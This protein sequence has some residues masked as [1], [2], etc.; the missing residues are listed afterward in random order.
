MI[1]DGETAAEALQSG[2]IDIFATSSGQVINDF[3]QMGDDSAI[4]LQ[5]ELTETNFIIIDQSKQNALADRRVRCALSMAID[6][7]ELIDATDGGITEPANGLFSPGQQG[8]LEDN[9]LV[10]EQDLEGAAALI[11]EY[12]SETGQ[13]AV[14][15]YGHTANPRER[16]GRPSCCSA[17]GTRSAST[18]RTHRYRRTSS[19]PWP[20]SA[21]RSS[22]PSAGVS[23]PASASTSST[24]G[25]TPP[26]R[27]PTA[28]SRSTSGGSTTRSS[29]RPS[30][31]PVRPAATKRPRA[32]A[33][34]VNRQFAENC[35]YIPT[36][37]TLWGIIS[38]PSVQG[39]GTFVM[40]DGAPAR[41]GAGFSG[42]YWVNTMFVEE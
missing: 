31:P 17:G 39:L 21:T 34:T 15:N 16:R 1:E 26:A 38:D 9:G 33:E 12:E 30:T 2:E 5:D 14:V 20:C 36:S 29:T 42:S 37:W 28:S 22:R 19:S 3:Q 11:E 41:D 18:L 32:A 23:T 25:G 4:N 6:R 40:P 35:Y 24:T 8:Y 27:T 10:M 7:Q 13:Q